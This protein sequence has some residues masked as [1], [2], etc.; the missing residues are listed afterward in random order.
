M[1]AIPEPIFHLNPNS[2][3][4]WIISIS[5][6]QP[7][8]DRIGDDVTCDSANVFFLSHCVI[9][10]AV[11]PEAACPANF[12][13]QRPRT[14]GFQLV[15]HFEK[16]RVSQLQEQV[17]VIGHYDPALD[18]GIREEGL[19]FEE[20]ADDSCKGEYLEPRDSLVGDGGDEIDAVYLRISS[21]AQGF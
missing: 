15:D 3:P 20:W 10:E 18:F 9:M 21:F 13:I 11:V 1:P 2:I 4:K 14:A 7:R 5:S 6:D 12:V 8:P 19:V 16:W 17:D